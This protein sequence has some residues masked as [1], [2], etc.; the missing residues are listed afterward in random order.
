MAVSWRVAE[1]LET[2]RLQ[3]NDAFPKRSK[4]SDGSI[5]DAKHASRTSDHNPWVKDSKNKG[6]V[7]ARDF[8]HDPKT[9]IDCQWLADTLVKHKDSRIKY[10][11]WNRQIC[12]GAKGK[13]PWVWR[14]YT[15]VNAHTHHLHLSVESTQTLFD[16]TTAWKLDFPKSAKIDDIAKVSTV[17]EPTSAGKT[18]V[19][20]S[21]P[22]VPPQQIQPSN[23]KIENN[24]N[25]NLPVQTP[26]TETVEITKTVA[27]EGVVSKTKAWFA[28]L[29]AAVTSVLGGIWA[30]L[31][32]ASTEIIIGF[33]AASALIA[34]A[35]IIQKAF[36]TNQREKRDLERQR[37]AHELTLAQ[38]AAARDPNSNTVVVK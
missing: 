7:T 17:D 18:T 16:N 10:I 33:F 8:T 4:V 27:E 20:D 31:S 22:E 14:K 34:I 13:S 19:I 26:V 35:W 25:V 30:W 1:A 23:I 24:E 15:G 28:A 3:L 9:G 21:T 32:G 11:I 2:L 29:P 12:S 36:L 38:I 6:V 37:M 5:G